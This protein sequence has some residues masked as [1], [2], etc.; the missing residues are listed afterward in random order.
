MT[1]TP[2][3]SVSVLAD[4]ER[5]GAAPGDG[6]FVHA[7]MRAVGPTVGGARAVVEALLASVGPAGLLAAPGFSTDAVFPPFLELT[8]LAAEKTKEV[9]AAVLGHDPARSSASEMGAI[10]ETLRTW[11]GTLRSRHPTTSVC[12]IGPDAETYAASHPD[13]WACGPDSPFGRLRD[14]PNMKMLLLGV[15]WNR[16]TALHTA[17]TLAPTRR[18]RMRRFKTGPGAAPWIETPDTA[19]D[20]GRLFPKV[21]AA[22][23]ETGAV[24]IGRVAGAEARLCGYAGLVAFAADWIDA[25]NRASGD[26]L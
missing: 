13:A 15:G 26:R 3:T 20:L 19:D 4:L 8:S 11:P 1:T 18:L 16:C 22:F 14:R 23:E 5:L 9:E 17:E 21:G 2:A 7:S 25:A 6:L 24:T 10:A 12:L